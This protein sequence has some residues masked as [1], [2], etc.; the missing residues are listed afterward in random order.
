MFNHLRVVEF[1][2][3]NQIHPI[4]K[5]KMINIVF[6]CEIV[7]S[8]GNKKSDIINLVKTKNAT[9]PNLRKDQY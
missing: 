8:N 5:T 9:L 1:L 4:F 7:I 6:A 2:S 3:Y